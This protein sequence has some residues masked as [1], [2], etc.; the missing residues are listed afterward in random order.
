MPLKITCLSGEIVAEADED[1][2]ELEFDLDVEM[3]RMFWQ[4]GEVSCW[5]RRRD[6]GAERGIRGFIIETNLREEGDG[7]SGWGD[8]S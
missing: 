4:R 3:S 1:V 7:G 5:G 6:R 2:S 8:M